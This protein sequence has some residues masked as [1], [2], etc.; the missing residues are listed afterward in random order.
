M[1][2]ANEKFLLEAEKRFKKTCKLT[3]DVASYPLP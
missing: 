1:I 3:C 2:S